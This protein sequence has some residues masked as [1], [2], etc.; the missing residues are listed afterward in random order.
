ME[1]PDD[2]VDNAANYWSLYFDETE[3]VKLTFAQEG[4]SIRFRIRTFSYTSRG[5][6]SQKKETASLER[7]LAVQT[8]LRS[9]PQGDRDCLN[10]RA[11]WRGWL[12]DLSRPAHYWGSHTLCFGIKYG[13]KLFQHNFRTA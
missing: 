11:F 3:K 2:R 9:R 7:K 12:F 1:N 6:A 4:M 13:L 8:T 5:L 10:F